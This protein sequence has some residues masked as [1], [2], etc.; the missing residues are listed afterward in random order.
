MGHTAPRPTPGIF[1]PLLSHGGCIRDVSPAVQEKPATVDGTKGG[2]QVRTRTDPLRGV[3]S[4]LPIWSNGPGLS[5]MAVP[6]LISER[7]RETPMIGL[8]QS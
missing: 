4:R 8:I 7:A 6:K 2:G 1:C 5:L 3:P